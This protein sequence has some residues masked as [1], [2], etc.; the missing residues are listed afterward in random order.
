MY[1]AVIIHDTATITGVS[2]SVLRLYPHALIPRG[3][4]GWKYT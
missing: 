1:L 4:M 3:L 2:G